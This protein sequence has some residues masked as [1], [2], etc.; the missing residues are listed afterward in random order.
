MTKALEKIKNYM[1]QHELTIAEM[2]RRLDFAPKNMENR[3]KKDNFSI[4]ELE[5]IQ[6][7]LGIAIF[8]DEAKESFAINEPPP[9]YGNRPINIVI[10][11][12]KSEG[13]PL[14]QKLEADILAFLAQEHKNGGKS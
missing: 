13:N 10:N 4:Q 6:E 3:L 14:A 2:A 8:A 5:L 12:G 7:R 1:E 11:L 9:D